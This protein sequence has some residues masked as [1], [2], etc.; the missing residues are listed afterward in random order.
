M[1]RRP[2]RSRRSRSRS[3]TTSSCTRT[4]SL[5]IGE[6]SLLGDPYLDVVTR[7]SEQPADARRRRQGRQ[8]PAQRE[9][10]R[11]ARLPRRGRARRR[12]ARSCAPS[13]AASRRGRTTSGSTAPSAACRG[14][15]RRPQ[16]LTRA[17]RGQ[18]EQIGRLV[19]SAGVVL[20]ELGRRED[21]DP[22]DRRLRPHHARRAR[23]R[24]AARSSAA[25]PSCPACSRPGGGRSTLARPLVA[26]LREPVRDL[27]ALS[28]DLARA[29]DPTARYS[30]RSVATDLDATLARHPGAAPRGRPDPRQGHPPA[31]AGSSRPLVR[32]I[33]APAR[34]L[35]PGARVPRRRRAR[36]LA[37]RGDRRACTPRSAPPTRARTARAATTRAPASPYRC[38]SSPTGRSTTARRRASATTPTRRRATR[39]TRSRSR[40][41]TRASPS[42]RC[43]R[44]AGRRSRAS[45]RQTM[46]LAAG[47][48]RRA[49]RPAGR[50]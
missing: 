44:A 43:R 16:Q 22:H 8:H 6:R 15:S 32:A 3:T 7:G 18:E 42:A 20:D 37:R 19:T 34:S 5:R 49:A 4:R 36:H 47:R 30:L 48:I 12:R 26:E 38:P 10:R 11:G 27:R 50:G 29:L 35:V 17:V 25:W 46:A 13:P 14:R 28:P 23:V 2:K 1:E 41:A 24:H 39:S 31:D 21:V 40:A 9:L 33:E 45:S